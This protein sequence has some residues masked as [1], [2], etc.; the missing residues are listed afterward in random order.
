MRLS[1]FFQTRSVFDEKVPKRLR[2]SLKKAFFFC[3]FMGRLF[4]FFAEKIPPV[5]RLIEKI[6]WKKPSPS[7]VGP[8]VTALVYEDS[9][10]M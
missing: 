6:H 3:L 9:V 5:V 7:L 8:G 4:A 10:A 1:F 2:K